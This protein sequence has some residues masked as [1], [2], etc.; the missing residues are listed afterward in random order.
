MKRLLI[1]AGLLPVLGGCASIVEGTDQQVTVNTTPEGA[2]CELTRSGEVIGVAN[3][4]PQ[5]LTLS[6]S[7]NDGS[8]VCEKA[9]FQSATAVLDSEFEAMTLGNLLVGGVIGVGVDAATGALNE[10]DSLITVPLTP[11]TT[12][13]APAVVPQPLAPTAPA[14]QIIDTVPTS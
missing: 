3:P 12:P 8:I 10:Y 5:T 1:V 14:I 2:K 6:K 9:G 13:T 11:V 7:K 4:T